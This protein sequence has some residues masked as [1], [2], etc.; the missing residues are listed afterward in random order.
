MPPAKCITSVLGN[1]IIYAW[2]AVFGPWPLG[3]ILCKVSN[4]DSFSP[5]EGWLLLWPLFPFLDN[6]WYSHLA[7][8]ETEGLPSGQGLPSGL[9]EGKCSHACVYLFCSQKVAV[10]GLAFRAYLKALG[11]CFQSHFS[12]DVLFPY[13]DYFLPPFLSFL[14]KKMLT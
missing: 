3:W 2:I 4:C 9:P 12:Q 1:L 10:Q 14:T 5:A 11:I 7:F 13:L 6:F 8:G